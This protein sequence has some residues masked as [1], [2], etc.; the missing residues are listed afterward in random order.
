MACNGSRDGQGRKEGIRYTKHKWKQFLFDPILLDDGLNSIHSRRVT[1]I[2]HVKARATAIS[3]S[4]LS[5]DEAESRWNWT[6]GR[7]MD[8]H[9][10]YLP[11]SFI[12][13][14]IAE[15]AHII[16]DGG[17]FRSAN[18]ANVFDG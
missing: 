7:P 14:A 3:C 18:N 6:V 10:R 1:D 16:A 11:T 13:K 17:P 8:H 15:A 9:K 2:R 4:R 5:M 12:G